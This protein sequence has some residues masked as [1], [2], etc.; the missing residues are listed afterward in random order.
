MTQSIR[1]L[2]AIL[3]PNGRAHLVNGAQTS[4]AGDGKVSSV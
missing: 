1:V 3:L 4:V 2:E